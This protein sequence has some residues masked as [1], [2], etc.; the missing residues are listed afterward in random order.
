M[1]DSH[2]ALPR[3][4]ISYS[5]DSAAHKAFVLQLANQLRADGL[6]CQLDQYVNGSPPEGWQRWMETQIEQADF[7][8]LVCTPTYLQR[9]RG[10]ATQSGRGVNFEGV[11][12]SQTLYDAF[13]HNT[14]FIPVLAADGSFNDVPLP[15]KAFSVYRL[16]VEYEDLYRVLTGQPRVAV[17][18]VGERKELHPLGELDLPPSPALPPQG[19][20]GDKR[21][22]ASTTDRALSGVEEQLNERDKVPMSDTMKAGLIGAGAVLLAAVLTGAVTLL[23]GGGTSVVVTDSP[24][25]DV[26]TGTQSGAQAQNC[27][28]GEQAE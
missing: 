5:H 10:Q 15:L 3:L 9:Y 27:E 22:R 18:E 14:K 2:N 6:D 13:Y 1:T 17:P 16:M 7:V 28:S 20:K 21:E 19:V 4:F 26:N 25:A 12:I 11:V 24:C 8:L 23:G